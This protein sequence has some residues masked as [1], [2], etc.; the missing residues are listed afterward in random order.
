LTRKYQY[1]EDYK[2]IKPSNKKPNS[3]SGLFYSF[4]SNLKFISL[5]AIVLILIAVLV[6]LIIWVFKEFRWNISENATYQITDAVDHIDHA[7]LENLL[8]QA[9]VEGRF[10]DAVRF[11]YLILIRSLNQQKIITWKKDK[12]NG[13][14]V[15]EMFGKKGFDLFKLITF[16]FERIWYGGIEIKEKDYNDLVP[17]FDQI[18][19][20]I[21]YR[22]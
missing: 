16:K 1:E 18:N 19:V 15:N 2:T 9:I 14:Y 22:G 20:I 21:N 4:L 3:Q 17:M 10:K 6:Y 5:I 13:H 8:H 11:R 7:N 12:T